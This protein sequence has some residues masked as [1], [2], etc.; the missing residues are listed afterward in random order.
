MKE[1]IKILFTK[2][3][4]FTLAIFFIFIAPILYLY[5]KSD[6]VQKTWVYKMQMWVM[7]F[8]ITYLI[9]MIKSLK[10]K[11]LETKSIFLKRFIFSF[12]IL[13]SF[14]IVWCLYGIIE[15]AFVAS[16]S[17][18]NFVMSFEL[19]GFI[20]YNFDNIMNHQYLQDL[21][22]QK[23]GKELAKIEEYKNKYINGEL[24]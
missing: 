17:F 5:I 23:K 19:I 7:P 6:G 11:L 4:A 24:K 1:K 16:D 3:L 14:G 13:A 22:W 15:K 10:T 18:F 8:L 9:I 20:L 21:E 12:N 2:R